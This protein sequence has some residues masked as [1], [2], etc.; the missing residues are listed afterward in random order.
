MFLKVAQQFYDILEKYQLLRR[1]T[2]E[3]DNLIAS[4]EEIA[5]IYEKYR[6]KSPKKR[7]VDFNQGTDARYV[8][9]DLMRLMSEI[10][11]R[12]LRIAFD[13]IGM[14]KK[15]ENA[16]RLAAKYGVKELSNYLL[17]NFKDKP[18]DLYERMRINVDLAEELGIHI[19]SFPMKY[20]PL[21]GED[22]KH[23]EFV[24]NHWNKKYVR[25]MQ[26]V[27]NVTKG[28][29]ADGRSFFHKAFGKDLEEFNELLYMPETYIV[30]RSVFEE[31][32]LTDIWRREFRTIKESHL[33]EEAK[34]IIDKSEFKNLEEKNRKSR[35]FKFFES[36]HYIKRRCERERCRSRKNK[37][38]V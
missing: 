33:W 16:V 20:I 11:I 18:N 25:A 8:T 13:Y 29:V 2:V 3:K 30:Y 19:F 17:Y 14:R 27:L 24:G 32:G 23:R 15:Y 1:E 31:A 6:D 10:P 35:H 4:Y 22:A 9:D 26:S 7:Y 37:R 36:L 5:P 38:A 21:F 28:I 34:A 12:P